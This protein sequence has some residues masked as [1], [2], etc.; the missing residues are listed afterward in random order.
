MPHG[1]P[2]Q[3]AIPVTKY[4]WTFAQAAEQVA[5]RRQKVSDVVFTAPF[6]KCLNLAL[7]EV[8]SIC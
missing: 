3:Q 2:P 7:L 6:I 1:E 4:G 8:W 5:Q